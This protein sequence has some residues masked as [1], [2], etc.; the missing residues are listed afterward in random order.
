MAVVSN[1]SPILNL[2]IVALLFLL[3]E[4]FEVITIPS[5]VSDELRYWEDLPGSRLVREA[6]E[7]GWIQVREVKDHSLV[8]SLRRDLD[9]GEAEAIALAVQLNADRVLLD[10]REARKASKFMGLKVLGVIAILIRAHNMGK[11]A[12]LK[13]AMEELRREA[14][15]FIKADLFDK[16]LNDMHNT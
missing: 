9:K 6:I 13:D 16:V 3:R 14:G 15:F 11:L 8:Q 7:A 10:E 12:S 1:T 5:A 4:Q 2:A